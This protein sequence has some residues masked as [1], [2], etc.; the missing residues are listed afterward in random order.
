MRLVQIKNFK[1]TKSIYVS[2]EQL[3]EL[4]HFEIGAHDILRDDDGD[5][6]IIMSNR[7]KIY[8]I[9]VTRDLVWN[10]TRA[11]DFLL[12]KASIELIECRTQNLNGQKIRCLIITNGAKNY[13]IDIPDISNDKND[14]S[15]QTP[16][17]EYSVEQTYYTSAG[18]YNPIRC[19]MSDR[20]FAVLYEG[21][22]PGP[23]ADG[24]HYQMVAVY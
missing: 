19:S 13:E 8:R 16:D 15:D 12:A 23:D 7:T 6:V 14:S 20:F 3:S 24:Q 5:F 18:M 21:A 11:V 9:N 10:S 22:H 2:N 4:A 17:F 1:V